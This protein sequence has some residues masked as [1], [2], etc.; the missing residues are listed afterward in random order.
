MGVGFTLSTAAILLIFYLYVLVRPECVKRCV[1]FL[2]GTCGVVLTLIAGFFAP[3]IGRTWASALVG[4]FTTIGSLVA[5][6]SAIVAC[7]GGK[8]PVKI[9]GTEK[10]PPEEQETA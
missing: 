9:P 6:G 7:Y 5:F 10:L 4:I 1:F 3:W 8:L 2:I